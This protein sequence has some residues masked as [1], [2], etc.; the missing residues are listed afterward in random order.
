MTHA[1]GQIIDNR[2]L[3]P[4]SGFKIEGMYG[5]VG[6]QSGNPT[7]SSW[8]E[9]EIKTS[10]GIETGRTNNIFA[11][12]EI[13]PSLAF[14]VDNDPLQ[15][16]L[17]I[18]V[19]GTMDQSG[20]PSNY[21]YTTPNWS[22]KQTV[23][24]NGIPYNLA[25]QILSQET[26]GNP[27]FTGAGLM[28]T[29]NV[30]ER[31]L[32]NQGVVLQNGDRIR[33]EVTADNSFQLYIGIHQ[34]GLSRI[35][36]TNE[37]N[38]LINFL[39][40]PDGFGQCIVLTETKIFDGSLAERPIYKKVF[41]TTGMKFNVDM[42]WVDIAQQTIVNNPIIS[43]ID[44][45]GIDDANDLCTFEAEN[46]NGYEDFD[47]CADV[48]PLTPE[49]E[50]VINEELDD[51]EIVIINEDGNLEIVENLD[52][53]NDGFPNSID[54][55]PNEPENFNGVQDFDGCPDGTLIDNSNFVDSQGNTITF[56]DETS[57][58]IITTDDGT[59]F[60]FITANTDDF[61]PTII[62]LE[63]STGIE[64]ENGISDECNAIFEN[65][66]EVIAQAIRDVEEATGIKLPFEPSI[67]NF[68]IIFGTVGIVIF[69]IGKAT[70]KI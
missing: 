26:S 50:E 42:T 55:C 56:D 62:I 32:A 54:F 7:S 48:I 64:T 68:V 53:D 31:L 12:A 19:V 58:P 35:V 67:L 9:W 59:V 21:C 24:V 46:Y 43:D 3:E 22:F 6:T 38:P 36:G 1:Y 61:N 14:N 27:I 20:I 15:N 40:N 29:P 5:G 10:N 25:R 52:T 11:I 33:W 2:G 13:I 8:L 60:D 30:L 37:F 49:Q 47:G 57:F 65:C 16:L 44:G 69:M 66:N 41:F 28:L 51:D 34:V 39:N 17:E 45:D 4:I 70:K 63:P 23:F 18:S